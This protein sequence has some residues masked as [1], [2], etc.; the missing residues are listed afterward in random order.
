MERRN[1]IQKDIILNAVQTL[2]SHV[3]AD[4]VYEYIHPDY[5][6]IGRGTVYRNLKVLAAEGKIRY[7]AVPGGAD[8]YDFTLTDHYHGHC[9]HCGKVFDVDMDVIKDLTGLVRNSQGVTYLDADI[10]F[11][12]ICS[13]CQ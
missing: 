12:G 13:K 6:S 10:H 7:V 5:P 11:R 3:T 4:D 9:I 1:T 8:H 2:R